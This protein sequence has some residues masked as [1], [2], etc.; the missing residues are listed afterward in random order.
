MVQQQILFVAYR[1]HLRLNTYDEDDDPPVHHH[2]PPVAKAADKEM[3]A[4]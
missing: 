2:K 1:I 4:F 3:M